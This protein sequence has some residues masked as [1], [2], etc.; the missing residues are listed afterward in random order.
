MIGFALVYKF[1]TLG[2]VGGTA[3]FLWGA[4]NADPDDR[5]LYWLLVGVSGIASVAYVLMS[6]GI[7]WITVGSG[8]V[9]FVPRYVD[10]ILTTPLLIAFLG[11]LAGCD[12][13]TVGRLIGINTAVMVLGTGAAL[14]DGPVSYGLFAVSSVAY[15]ALLSLLLGVVTDSAT[16][17]DPAT[18]S[19]FK[20]LRN[21]TVI[22]WSVYPII[23]LLGPPGLGVL[24]TTVDVLLVVYLDLMT[25]VGFG[26][27]GL[28]AG[29][30]LE[31]DIGTF[32]S[33]P[34]NGMESTDA[35]GTTGADATS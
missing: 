9:V 30:V 19:L 14:T 25:K 32:D 17:R 34:M 10:W 5:L 31:Q 6:L 28:N 29:S 27:I 1:G 8:R 12:R 11:L 35:P 24:T 33:D 15:V 16:V 22:L 4:V 20:S 13:R 2:M 23:W 21:L 26:L 7:G 3:A 18:L